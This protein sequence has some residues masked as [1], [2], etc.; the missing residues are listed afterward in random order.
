M[1]AYVIFSGSGPILVPTT[2]ASATDPRLVDKLAHKGI[3]SFIAHEVPLERTGALYGR[4]FDV[5][6]ADL[7]GREDMRVLDLPGHHIVSSFALEELGE[8]VKVG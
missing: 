5:V 4:A 2:Y 6:A 8:A 3:A 1:R 7:A